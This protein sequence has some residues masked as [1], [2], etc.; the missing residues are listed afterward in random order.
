MQLRSH[1]EFQG[2]VVLECGLVLSPGAHCTTE[3]VW[4][5]SGDSG[6]HLAECVCCAH[7]PRQMWARRPTFSMHG[8]EQR[9]DAPRREQSAGDTHQRP[10]KVRSV[11][12]KR[13][14]TVW[15]VTRCQSRCYGVR[16]QAVLPQQSCSGAELSL[17]CQFYWRVVCRR[18]LCRAGPSYLDAH[19]SS[20]A[21][22]WGRMQDAFINALTRAH[23][24]CCRLK[25]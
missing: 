7:I 25:R 23:R 18:L 10:H 2:H 21:K 16:Y 24:S 6:P 17:T 22:L 12:L 19:R 1:P 5:T 14:R 4:P 11:V 13:S 8:T 15:P 20:R 9:S 3:T